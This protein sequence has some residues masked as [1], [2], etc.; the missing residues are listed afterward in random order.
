HRGDKTVP[1]LRGYVVGGAEIGRG[2]RLEPDRADGEGALVGLIDIN[3]GPVP[4]EFQ[5][6][7]AGP[8]ASDLDALMHDPHRFPTVAIAV[9][10]GIGGIELVDVEVFLVDVEDGQPEGDGAVVPDRDSRQRWLARAD[11]RK[12]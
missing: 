7:V 2:A 8:L 12:T 4:G 5:L 6:D 10:I 3:D 9:L 11:H 1:V